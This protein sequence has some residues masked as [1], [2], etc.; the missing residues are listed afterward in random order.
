MSNVARAACRIDYLRS[1]VL[2]R[3]F[4][5]CL[6]VLMTTAGAWAQ[7]PVG[8]IS[9]V[10]RDQS[11]AVVPGVSITIRN[12]GTGVERNVVSGSDG[13]FSAPSLAAGSYNVLA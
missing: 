12:A 3:S 13:T 5:M 9:G 1:S 6:A 7:A 11:D 8:T 2:R 4:G 10:V